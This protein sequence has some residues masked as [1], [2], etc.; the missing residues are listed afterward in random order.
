MNDNV[1]AC[2]VCKRLF[3]AFGEEN[4]CRECMDKLEEKYRE[5]KDYLWDHGI[6]SIQEISMACDVSEEQIKEW[7]KEERL[8]MAD[9][10]TDLKCEKCKRPI[11]TGRYCK[12]CKEEVMKDLH[13]VTA[14]KDIKVVSA[15]KKQPRNERM[16]FLDSYGQQ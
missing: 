16:R 3:R 11:L 1:K 13:S 5:V 7:L 6:A 14:K 9:G 2:R 4:T 10:S 8:S 15:E 12:E